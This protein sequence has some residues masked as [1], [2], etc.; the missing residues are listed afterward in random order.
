MAA[1]KSGLGRGL[2][3]L[4]PVDRPASGFAELPIEAQPDPSFFAWLDRKLADLGV[5]TT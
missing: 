1:R 3:A 5:A 2:D 4:I